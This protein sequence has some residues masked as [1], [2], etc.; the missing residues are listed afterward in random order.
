MRQDPR[1]L[2][3]AR[4]ILADNF[5]P[6]PTRV[7]IIDNGV[8]AGIN[9]IWDRVAESESFVEDD[10]KTRESSVWLASH[11]H[12][13]QMASIV[14]DIDPHCLLY[15]AKVGTGKENLVSPDNIIAVS[16]MHHQYY[17]LRLI[18][19]YRLSSGWPNSRSTLW[20]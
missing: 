6:R 12:G 10:T 15:I 4:E 9:K 14:T 20:S 18:Q 2:I 13:T 5:W 3:S 1:Q 17:N 7:A 16:S 8:D 11:P 19:K